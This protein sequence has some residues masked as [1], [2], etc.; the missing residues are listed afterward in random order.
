M[1]AGAYRSII[2][3]QWKWLN[4]PC[5]EG[6]FDIQNFWLEDN[7]KIFIDMSRL[8]Q[9]TITISMTSFDEQYHKRQ[10]ADSQNTVYKNDNIQIMK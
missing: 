8:R 2:E 4:S 6:D 7:L 3:D 1:S 9:K 10:E 5:H